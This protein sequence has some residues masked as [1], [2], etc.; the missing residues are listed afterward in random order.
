MTVLRRPAHLGQLPR[1]RER[2]GTNAVADGVADAGRE[3]GLELRRG[4]GEGLDLR[5][6][7][8]ERGVDVPFPGAALGGIG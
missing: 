5:A 2:L 3:R 4:L 1:D 8:F 6:R 7:T